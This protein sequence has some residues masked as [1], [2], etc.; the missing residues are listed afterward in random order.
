MLRTKSL[1]KNPVFTGNIIIWGNILKKLYSYANSYER[2]IVENEPSSKELIHQVEKSKYLAYRPLVSII[3]PVYNTPSKIIQKTINSV[4]KQTYDNW[5]LCLVDGNSTQVKIKQILREWSLKEPRIQVKFLDQNFGISG[6][7]NEALAM[8]RG[9]FIALLDHDDELAPFALFEVANFLN[10]CSDCDVIYSDEDKI[11]LQGN[12]SAPFFK[13]DWSPE[14]LRSVMYIGHL[15][16]YRHQLVKDVGGFR[17]EFD[18]SQDYDLAWRITEVAKRIV[19]IPKVLYHWRIIKGS[20][21]A[22]DKGFAKKT[23]LAAL[24]SAME[25]QGY[26]AEIL[27]YPT[28]NR[29]K[30]KFN[31]LPLVSIII[32]TDNQQILFD[33]LNGLLNK[34]SYSQLEIVV[35]TNSKLSPKIKE[36]YGHSSVIKTVVFDAVFS[37]SAKC[38]QGAKNAWG[39]YLL[40]LNDDVR[41]IDEDWVECMLEMIQ[42]EGVGGVSPKLIYENGVIQYAG[43]VTG[44]RGFVGTAFHQHPHDST[45]YFN[46]AQSTRTV[47]ILSGACCLVRKNVFQK[48]G[49]WDEINTPITGSDVD[50]SFKIREQGWRLAYTPFAK[51]KQIGYVSIGAAKK[52]KNNLFH[53]DKSDLYLLKRWGR[54]LSYDPYYTDNMRYLLYNDSPTRYKM[55]TNNNASANPSTRDILLVSHDLTWSGAPLILQTLAKCLQSNGYF[56]TIVAPESGALIQEYQTLNI[57]VI[58]E[59][60]IFYSPHTLENLLRNYDLVI[61]NTI[62][63]YSVVLACKKIGKSVVWL[64]HEGSFGQQLAESSLSIQQAFIEAD[65]IVFPSKQAESRY[66]KFA[67]REN[68]TVIHYGIDLRKIKHTEF[69]PQTSPPQKIR[70]IQVGSIE[71]RKGQDITVKAIQNL[72]KILQNVFEFYFVGRTLDWSYYNELVKLTA[73]LKNVHWIGEVPPVEALGYISE[74]DVVVCSSRDEAAPTF[75]LEGMSFQKPIISTLVGVVPEIIEHGVNG[76]LFDMEDDQGLT[77]NLLHLYQNPDLFSMFGKL[78][79]IKFEELFTVEKY[80]KSFV[81]LIEKVSVN[82]QNKYY[83]SNWQNYET[84]NI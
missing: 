53:S 46:L 2:W 26:K 47:S 62:L 17:S 33:C 40:F 74:S 28:A 81:S 19:H 34:T 44:V 20:A 72:L 65:A 75:V 80:G 1:Q 4:V 59:P 39:E 82:N 38:N 78:G 83:S 84:K 79:L 32:P 10:D 71:P 76:L 22:G 3:T 6:N 63:S 16:V 48:I 70:A 35:V 12:R 18:F 24:G 42:Y 77:N 30:I 49:G 56:V 73:D 55:Y 60:L 68:F 36:E 21:A 45:W 61:A 25:R 29:A 50:F 43:M 27:K 5:Q 7:S 15:T 52:Q 31:E 69:S 23:N 37:F 64:I 66:H 58:I 67:K 13:P 14:L 41:P 51:L 9:E 54:Y 57:P 11:D 8:A